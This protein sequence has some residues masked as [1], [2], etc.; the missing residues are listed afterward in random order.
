MSISITEYVDITSGVG[1]GTTVAQRELITRL[2]TTNNAIPAG[3]VVEVTTLADVETLFGTNSDEYRRA[4]KYFGWV[5]KSV[6][7]AKKI[8]FA[9][10]SETNESP[11]IRGAA[12]VTVL[13][14]WQAIANG[15]FSLQ[16]GTQAAQVE[17]L[18][19][20]AAASL[21]DVA[22]IIQTG[23]RAEAG[24]NFAGA[25]VTFDNVGQRF[26]ASFPGVTAVPAAVTVSAPVTGTSLINPVGWTSSATFGSGAAAQ[27]PLEAITASTVLS[28]NFGSFGFIDDLSLEQWTEIGAW[29]QAQNVKYIALVPVTFANR[30]TWSAAL[31]T[32]GGVAMTLVNDTN[33]EHDE[34]IPGIILAATDYTKRN[35]A[36]NYMF[37]TFSG[38]SAKVTDTAVSR[39][40]NGLRINYYGQTQTAGQNLT[41]YQRGL[42][43]GTAATPSQMGVFGNEMWFKSAATSNLMSLLLNLPLIPATDEGRA[44]T[45][46]RLQDVINRALFNGTFATGKDLTSDQKAYI[47]QI[48]DDERAWHQVQNLGY[49]I[50]A[51]VTQTT[52]SESGVTEYQIDYTLLYSKADAVNKITG[53]D[54]LI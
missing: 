30:A 17:D 5:S 11:S 6:T 38:V 14:T 50:D 31:S 12:P 41:F 49:W 48:T 46:A 2:F 9:H 15:A 37:N 21:A 42:L 10:F 25:T 22:S 13:A 7:K 53:R 27:S 51:V 33:T 36:P 28:D 24:S 45:L 35:A 3:S 44:M 39:E 1:A 40:L 52:N 20:T 34:D 16:V 26:N 43:G 19:F 18:D 54:I 8:S 23:I 29:V 32:F 47:V 4:T